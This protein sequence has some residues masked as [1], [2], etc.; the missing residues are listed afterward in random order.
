MNTDHIK[1]RNMLMQVVLVIVTLGIYTIYWYYVTLKEMHIANG[2]DKWVGLWAGLWTFLSAIPIVCLF[3]FWYH[4][5]EFDRFNNS[6]YSG[7]TILI[8]WIV[9]SPGFVLY[10]PI[11]WF[12]VQRDLNRVAPDRPASSAGSPQPS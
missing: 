8:V 11:A 6:K 9:T 7:L 10:S 1:Y 5:F 2:E 4:S 12:L 3:A